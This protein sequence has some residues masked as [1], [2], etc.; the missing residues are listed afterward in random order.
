MKYQPLETFLSSD[1]ES[2][3]ST[4]VGFSLRNC[5]TRVTVTLSAS[6]R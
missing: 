5:V 3:E 4:S 1:Q 2:Q 6:S